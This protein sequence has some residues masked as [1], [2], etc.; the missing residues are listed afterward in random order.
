MALDRLASVDTST[1]GAIEEQLD[2]IENNMPGYYAFFSR[3]K[4]VM[5]SS[6]SKTKM[7]PT[8][9]SPKTPD[10]PTHPVNPNNTNSSTGSGA[11]SQG[12][13]EE[14]VKDLANELIG[15]VLGVMQEDFRLIS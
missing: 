3:L 4:V 10:Q 14:S 13:P 2:W 6:E 9:G 11:S 12:K 8:E 5:E 1:S 15:R 7:E